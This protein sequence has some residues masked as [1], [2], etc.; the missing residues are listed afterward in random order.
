MELLKLK[1][2]L[3]KLKEPL[4]K[5]KEPLVKIKEPLVKLYNQI[6]IKSG[7]ILII[8]FLSFIVLFSET[9]LTII[10][11]T[12]LSTILLVVLLSINQIIM[13]YSFSNYNNQYKLYIFLVSILITFML[14]YTLYI[15]RI[16]EEEAKIIEELKEK[17][18]IE[19]TNIVC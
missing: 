8:I 16:Y 15:K 7:I 14:L 10:M 12:N 9:K 6:T 11:A 17:D 18:I 4:V 2:P 1:E 5:L 3:V 19:D 13:Y